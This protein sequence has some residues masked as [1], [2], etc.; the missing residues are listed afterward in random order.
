MAV[1]TENGRDDEY[2]AAIEGRPD[3]TDH[4]F[5]I[6]RAKTY[7]PY[8]FGVRGLSCLVHK[9]RYVELHW[10]RVGGHRGE[11]LVKLKR[12]VMIAT[13]NCQQSFR[14]DGDASRTCH[15]PSPDAL[16]CGRCQGEPAT[17]PRRGPAKKSGLTRQEAHVKLGCVV[18]GY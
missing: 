7:P 16:L 8:V 17:F 14:L 1:I 13:T 18:K 11:C 15:L 5:G 3:F 9:V 4:R 6:T 12:P 2:V 10:W